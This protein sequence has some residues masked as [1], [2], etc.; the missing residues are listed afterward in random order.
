MRNGIP[1]LVRPLI[2]YHTPLLDGVHAEGFTNAHSTDKKRTNI[3]Q[4]FQKLHFRYFRNCISVSQTFHFHFFMIFDFLWVSSDFQRFRFYLVKIIITICFS[5]G[6]LPGCRGLAAT[7]WTAGHRQKREPRREAGFQAALHRLRVNSWRLKLASAQ[8][9][10]LEFESN[11]C[12]ATLFVCIRCYCRH[13]T[14]PVD[15][16]RS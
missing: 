2:V 16:I 12:Y 1:Y 3:F 15:A 14:M 9:Y 7:L 8:V 10:F 11:L 4:I 13:P 6:Y 5:R